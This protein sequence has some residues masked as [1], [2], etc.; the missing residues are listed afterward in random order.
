LITPLFLTSIDKKSTV[1]LGLFG[2]EH[3]RDRI[4]GEIIRKGPGSYLSVGC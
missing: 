2:N 1:D 4:F 3:E